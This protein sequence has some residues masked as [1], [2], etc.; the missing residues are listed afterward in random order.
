MPQNPDAKAPVK[1][2][3][4]K[5]QDLTNE[6]ATVAGAGT[7]ANPEEFKDDSALRT[8]ENPVNS[9][10]DGDNPSMPITLPFANGT[11]KRNFGGDFY[12]K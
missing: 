10:P 3:T 11:D 8:N 5:Q 4:S 7:S 12:G 2:Y 9:K 6:D 1:G